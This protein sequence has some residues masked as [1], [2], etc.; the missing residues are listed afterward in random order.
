ML[1]IELIRNG[2][3][4]AE[5]TDICND[6]GVRPIDTLFFPVQ[7]ASDCICVSARARL[8]AI[9]GF[10]SF[11]LLDYAL[12]LSGLE[13]FASLKRSLLC[14]FLC[15]RYSLRLALLCLLLNRYRDDSF[16]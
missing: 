16:L 7:V 3:V 1:E 2:D 15:A 14:L 11:L 10:S 13:F 5:K 12:L 8:S 4:F 6:G 9:R